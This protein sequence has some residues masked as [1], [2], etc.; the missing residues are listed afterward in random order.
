[1]GAGD[2]SASTLSAKG[3][4]ISAQVSQLYMHT[5]HTTKA[6]VEL[7]NK[8]ALVDGFVDE[9]GRTKNEARNLMS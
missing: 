9:N 4:H 8:P 6:A 7:L 1:M 3:T 5:L 2:S